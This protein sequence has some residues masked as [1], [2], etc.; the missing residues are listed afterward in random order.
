MDGFFPARWRVRLVQLVRHFLLGLRSLHQARRISGFLLLTLAI[1]LLDCAGVVVLARGLS[2]TLSPM[3]SV[4][5]LTS[6]GL[7]SVVPGAPGNVGVYQMAAV[8]VLLPFGVVRTQALG[9]AVML[10]ILG[11][12]TLTVWGLGSAWYLSAR[13]ARSSRR[14]LSAV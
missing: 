13:S 11:T 8:A 3:I 9:F 14:V 1:W 2:M 10:Q 7:S 12:V 5:I 4:L 6:I